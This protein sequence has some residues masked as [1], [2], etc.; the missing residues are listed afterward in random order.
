MNTI[1]E[2]NVLIMILRYLYATDRMITKY[3]YIYWGYTVRLIYFEE[4]EYT[5]ND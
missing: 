4:W 3:F 5:N 1:S 2:K